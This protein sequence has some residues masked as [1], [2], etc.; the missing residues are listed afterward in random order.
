[1][2]LG[3]LG[4]LVTTNP[5]PV[6]IFTAASAQTVSV[7]VNNNTNELNRYSIGVST[8]LDSIEDKEYVRKNN[9]ISPLEVVE[10]EKLYL[11][12]SDT[13]VVKSQKAGVSFCV[14]GT[15]DGGDGRT[16]SVITTDSTKNKNLTVTTASANTKYT[17]AINNQNYDNAKIY[18]GV[19][20]DGD[21]NDGWII[22]AQTI[23]PGANFTINDLFLRSNQ[24]IIVKAST[25]DI[26]FTPLSILL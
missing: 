4:S 26:S 3:K 21:L 23:T 12:T 14:I 20:D 9:Y 17:I 2:A 1:M 16:Q 6:G 5:N 18:V 10:V 22:F 24:S 13:L 7:Y 11:D 8:S 19:A 15:A 25:K